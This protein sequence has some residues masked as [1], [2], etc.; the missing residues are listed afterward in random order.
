VFVGKSGGCVYLEIENNERLEEERD[1]IYRH[2]SK[3]ICLL[4]F[5]LYIP[6]G[7]YLSRS[8]SVK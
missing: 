2:F 7:A 6:Y 8:Q 5:P 3:E 1:V 4:E